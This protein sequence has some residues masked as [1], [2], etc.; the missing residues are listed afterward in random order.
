MIRKERKGVLYKEG[1]GGGGG[2]G[3]GQMKGLGQL[4][5]LSSCLMAGLKKKR[6]INGGCRK[7]RG[8]SRWKHEMKSTT[9]EISQAVKFRN[10]RNSAS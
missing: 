10:L 4:M 2:G 3:G 6:K 1:G 8:C 5:V 7:Q 9:C